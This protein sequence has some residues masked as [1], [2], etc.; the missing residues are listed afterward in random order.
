M[1]FERN[2]LP[3][4]LSF[5]EEQ[6]MNLIGTGKWQKTLCPFHDDHDPSLSINSQNGAFYCFSCQTK[7]GDIISFLMQKDKL[8]FVEAVKY[9]GAWVEDDKGMN[10]NVL[11]KKPKPLS[12]HDALEILKFEALLCAVVAS[13]VASG[14]T[15]SMIDKERLMQ[16]VGRI[17]TIQELFS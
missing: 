17:Q 15:L 6:G 12:A 5:Y 16:A 3:N 9:L 14:K 10:A 2:N 11:Y 13:D 8:N 1:R 4:P 7:G